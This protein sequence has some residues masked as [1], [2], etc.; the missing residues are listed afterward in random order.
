M[1]TTS[2]TL[3]RLAKYPLLSAEEEIVCG[4]AVQAMQRILEECPSGPY[5]KDQKRILRAGKRAKDRM[6]TGNMRWVFTLARKYMPLAISLTFDDLVQEGTIGLIRGVE[7]FDVERG[8]KL[9]TYSYWWI[10][11]GINRGLAT[12][13]MIRLPTNA[14][15]LLRK[16]WK[17]RDYYQ[18][19]FGKT[20]S[21]SEIS[22][23][24]SISKE[25]VKLLLQRAL[26][27]TSLDQRA[28]SSNAEASSIGELIACDRETPWDTAE[29][30]EREEWLSLCLGKISPESRIMVS[31]YWGLGDRE[32][33]TFSKMA[34]QIDPGRIKYE[35]TGLRKRLSRDYKRGIRQLQRCAA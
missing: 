10:R 12:D 17:C 2:H 1:S 32:P 25:H 29:Q 24:T 7:K 4:R 23:H 34:D 3:D 31:S 16:I 33:M 15:D 11:Q 6:V 9:S 20:P 8:Y 26:D 30:L 28:L 19:T 18:E 5:S 21:I 14:G 22:D 27:T 13:R 35:R